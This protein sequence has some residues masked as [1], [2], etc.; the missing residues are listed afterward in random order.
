MLMPESVAEFLARGG[1]INK[2]ETGKSGQDMAATYKAKVKRSTYAGYKHK[3]GV[4]ITIKR[5]D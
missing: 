5:T 2:I 3:S 4:P 1:T